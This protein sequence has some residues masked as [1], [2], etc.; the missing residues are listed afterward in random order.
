MNDRR[1]FLAA[2]QRWTQTP[3]TALGL[4]YLVIYA[5]QVLNRNQRGVYD[6]CELLSWGI[7]AIFLIDTII[8]AIGSKSAVE[9]LKENWLSL[10]ALAVPFARILRIMRAVIGLRGFSRIAAN[11]ATSTTAYI[12]LLLPIVWFTG[13]IAV[14]DA[15]GSAT[16]ASITNLRE[17]LWWSLAT[18]TTVGYGDKY[19]IT[20]E[21]QAIAAALMFAGIA[22]FSAVAGIFASWVLSDR[23]KETDEQMNRKTKVSSLVLV[24]ALA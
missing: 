13:A 7:W 12:G 11:R 3:L 2:W 24:A 20:V 4:A 1:R 9:F 5:V 23:K 21:G 22:L 14:L 19:P 15:E 10:I 18:L 17:A 16:E 6:L 8:Q